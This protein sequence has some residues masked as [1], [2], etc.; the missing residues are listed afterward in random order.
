MYFSLD[1][2]HFS[3]YIFKYTLV[4]ITECVNKFVI[5]LAV[6]VAKLAVVQMEANGLLVIV[7]HMVCNTRIICIELKPSP[8]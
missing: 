7:Y 3:I 5:Y 1:H 2:F 4:F 8:F 6:L